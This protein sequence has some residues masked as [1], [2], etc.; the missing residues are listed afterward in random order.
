MLVVDKLVGVWA[1]HLKNMLVKLDH[2]PRDRVE[3]K[4]CLKPPPSIAIVAI[5]IIHVAGFCL[6]KKILQTNCWTNGWITGP[7]ASRILFEPGH[8]ENL[9]V[10]NDLWLHL[11]VS[12]NSGT[13]KSSILTGFSI[14][15][16]PFWGTPILGNTHLTT[17]KVCIPNSSFSPKSGLRFFWPW[18]K[19]GWELKRLVVGKSTWNA[20]C[21][22]LQN[23]PMSPEKGWVEKETTSSSQQFSAN[24]LLFRG[25][26][27]KSPDM[28]KYSSWKKSCIY[29]YIYMYYIARDLWK[30][31]WEILLR[32]Q[33][34]P[35]IELWQSQLADTWGWWSK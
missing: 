14:R 23:E 16:H 5:V 6:A 26:M 4:K 7:L 3:N 22:T 8:V 24:M 17:V 32:S 30:N 19:N 18:A 33:N 12:E 31:S 20:T 34:C 27:K 11:G 9:F 15:N 35:V 2:F 25:V 1:T 28:L 13:P 29:I 21:Y 10:D